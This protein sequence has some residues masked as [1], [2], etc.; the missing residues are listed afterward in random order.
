MKCLAVPVFVLLFSSLGAEEHPFGSAD[1]ALGRQAVQN[2]VARGRDALPE[3]RKL[4]QSPDPRIAVR[5]KEALGG[6][7]GHWGSQ[8]DLIWKRSLEEAT[9]K[10][11]PILLLQ[12]FGNLNEEF[13]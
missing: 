6:I 10:G 12:L 11:K 5:A 7:T 1:P 3:L 4:S 2:Y 8:V 9:G 13:C